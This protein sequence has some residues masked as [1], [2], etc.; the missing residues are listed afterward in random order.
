M[1]LISDCEAC[2]RF[3]LRRDSPFGRD[4]SLSSFSW[5]EFCRFGAKM[6]RERLLEEQE[7]GDP[8]LA[9]AVTGTVGGEKGSKEVKVASDGLPLLLLLP[10]SD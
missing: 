5:I 8:V 3:V 10:C 6:D 4:G 1:A 2:V 7:S 9:A